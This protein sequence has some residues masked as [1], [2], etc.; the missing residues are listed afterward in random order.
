M[1]T[2]NKI[3]YLLSK[4]DRR[5][6]IFLLL[7]V[8]L[9]AFLD[10][11]GVASI[12]PFI[13]I[14]TNPDLVETNAILKTMYQIANMFGVET[15]QEF[16]F[17]LGIL[18]FV[19]LLVS[20]TFKALTTYAQLLFIQMREYSISKRLVE[21][22]L[23]QPYTW[24][25][26]RHSADLGKSILS[27][28]TLIIENGLRPLISVVAQSLVA[29]ALITLLILSNP[30]LAII[31]SLTLGSVYVIT[32]KFIRGFLKKIGQERVKTNQLRFTSVNEA[33]SAFK[34]V[35][36]KGL[37]ENYI[38][39]FADPAHTF[40]KHNASSQVIS[41]LP[42]FALE[43]IAFGGMLL[44]V[45]YLMLQTGK[46]NTALP[47]IALYAFAGY[48]LMPAIQGIYI[49]IAQ[50]RYIGPALDNMYEELKNLK[51]PNK[52]ENKNLIKLNEAINLKNIYY[53]Y[54]NTNKN[55]LENISLQIPAHT[56]IGLVGATGSGKTTTVDIILGLLEPF[57][58]TLEVDGKV[59]NKD[60]YKSWQQT[61]GY[62][63]QE[64]FL[65]D[66]TIF[67]NIAFGEEVQ[68]INKQAVE[69]VAKIANLHEFII[70][71]LPKQYETKVGERG[72]RLSGGQ[73]QR[74]GIARALYHNPQLLVLDEGTSSLDNL[75]EYEVM[76]TLNNLKN[77]IT[78]ILIAHRLNTVKKCD[79]I[80]V[81]NNGKLKEQ[82]S[83]EELINMNKN[84]NKMINVE[85][86]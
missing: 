40:A 1:Q 26:D 39:R 13:V 32:Y 83:F 37:E 80:F 70:N 22:Y 20:L 41:Q 51:S 44:L 33:F 64:I 2:I 65:A 30:E 59:I 34:V 43:A 23:H 35:K 47:F 56:T 74:I 21:T 63:P 9:M 7:I 29:I 71:E 67:A 84:F 82:G 6:L 78:I 69:R 81:L 57:K 46:L 73:R 28:V 77:G 14:L 60:N 12:L 4:R 62:V 79:K 53:R 49:G 27:E 76:Q 19:I 24:F 17:A 72:V 18:S 86:N 58:G 55:V 38:K 5:R 48:R 25:L 68:K 52:L 85:K 42:H 61:I 50:L 8:I 10:M 66:D 45:L 36:V 15:N 11:L 16:I 75:T 54:P 3:L 31:V